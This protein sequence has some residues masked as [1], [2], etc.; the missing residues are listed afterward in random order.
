MKLERALEEKELKTLDDKLQHNNRLLRRM[1]RFLWVWI[2]LALVIGGIVFFWMKNRNEVYLLGTTVVLYIGIG[3]WVAGK[4]YGALRKANKSIEYLKSN[5][6]V[7]VV[8]VRA[9]KYYELKEQE[10][11]G[12][13]YLFQLEEDKVLSFGGQEFYPNSQFPNDQFDIV[14]ARGLYNEVLLL[15][16]YTYGSKIAPLLVLEG[17]QKWDVLSS[18]QYPDPYQMTIVNGKVEDFI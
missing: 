15:E 17:Q 4:D 8:S 9:D 7:T 5:N 10:D 13:F 6:R 1:V 12:V 18:G 14:E 11:E 2:S 3:V 16:I